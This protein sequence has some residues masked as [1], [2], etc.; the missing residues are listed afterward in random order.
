MKYGLIL[1]LFLGVHKMGFGQDLNMVIEVNAKTV[2]SQIMSAYLI[3]KH[4]DGTLTKNLIGYRPGKLVLK[5]EDWSEINNPKTKTITLS[6][7]YYP[8]DLK[9]HYKHHFDVAL[10]KKH[11]EQSYLVLK[12]Y[13]FG[14]KRFRKKYSCLTDAKYVYELIFPGS[15]ALKPCE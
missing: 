4:Q 15:V 5:P 6:F 2:I 3:F 7:D 9:P 14:T 10:E 13:N 12:V 11:F 8:F 1:L